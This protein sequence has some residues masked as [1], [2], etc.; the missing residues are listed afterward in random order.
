VLIL[1]NVLELNVIELLPS[2]GNSLVQRDFGPKA[3]AANEPR[4]DHLPPSNRGRDTEKGNTGVATYLSFVIHTD[5]R[6]WVAVH[7]SGIRVIL[8][9]VVATQV[10]ITQ[11]DP[12]VTGTVLLQAAITSPIPKN[13]S[14]NQLHGSNSHAAA[15]VS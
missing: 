10:R 5:G 12:Q 8:C 2:I 9:S 11:M 15:S 14:T 1:F 6:G 3:K 4:T 13:Q 7:H